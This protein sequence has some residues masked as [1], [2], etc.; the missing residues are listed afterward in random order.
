MTCRVNSIGGEG[1]RW[2]AIG[3]NLPSTCSEVN[4][5]RAIKNFCIDVEVSAF[6]IHEAR[7]IFMSKNGQAW[8]EVLYIKQRTKNP[9][10]TREAPQG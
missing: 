6:I 1:G 4:K 7:K 9:Q 10:Y 5:T 2:S 3:A 8:G